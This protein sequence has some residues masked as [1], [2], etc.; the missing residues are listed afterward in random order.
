MESVALVDADGTVTVSGT[1]DPVPWWSVTKTV[2]AIAALRLVEDG[3]LSLNGKVAGEPYTLAHL[4]RHEAGLPDYGGLA[5]YHEDVQAGKSPWPVGRLLQAL[6]VKRPRYQ[7]GNGWA[8]SNI[9]Y[10]KVRQLIE[11]ATGL[12]L[13]DALDRLVFTPAGLTTARL[14]TQPADLHDVEMGPAR[15]DY[16]PGWVYH[17]LVT[18][19]VADA[20]RLLKGLAA[21]GL[22]RP[23]TF[24]SML[25][26]RA[27]PEHR[28]EIFKDPAYGLGLMLTAGTPLDHP[29]G[30]RGA[31]PGSTVAAYAYGQRACAIWHAST[32]NPDLVVD[33][34]FRRLTQG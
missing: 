17:G 25:D 16:H 24:A 21:G 26:H 32:Q 7:P 11:E 9:G 6:D 5:R 19:T 2:L 20:A 34:V 27:L 28:N 23:A 13:A 10:L 30:H 22:L 8:Y 3:S 14:A 33:M 29:I 15:A 18:G 1:L 4:L 12:S 31:G